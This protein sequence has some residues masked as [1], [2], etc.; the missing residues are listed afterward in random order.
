MKVVRT[1]VVCVVV[2]TLLCSDR[3]RAQAPVQVLARDGDTAPGAGGA[4]LNGLGRVVINSTGSAAFSAGL[5]GNGVTPDNDSSLWRSAGGI[6]TLIAREDV[7]A[8]GTPVGIRFAGFQFPAINNL[9]QVTFL[10]NL[11]GGTVNDTN[12]Y[13][14]W[15]GL[16]G[17]IQKAFRNGD[18]VPGIDAT[19]DVSVGV[20]FGYSS[21]NQVAF[22]GI[23]DDPAAP[24][25]QFGIWAGAPGALTPVAV[26][27]QQA[28]DLPAGV[29]FR[30]ALLPAMSPGGQ[31][32]FLATL[33]GPGISLGSDQGIWIGNT[34]TST[35]IAREGAAA[36]DTTLATYGNFG[37]PSI[38]DAGEIAFTN[39]LTGPGADSNNQR[40]IFAGAPGAIALVARE[41]ETALGT[42]PGVVF[43][44]FSERTLITGA[45]VVVSKVTLRGAG[46]SSDNNDGIWANP[47]GPFTRVARQGDP[48]P[49][50]GAL[51]NIVGAPTAN[52]HGQAAFR[53][54]LSGPDVNNSNDA[55]I[56]AV[57]PFN[58]LVLVAREGDSVRLGLG[59]DRILSSNGVLLVADSGGQDGFGSAFN[60]ASQLGLAFNFEDGTSAAIISRVGGTARVSDIAPVLGAAIN[61]GYGLGLPATAGDIVNVAGDTGYIRFADV[62]PAGTPMQILL[63]FGGTDA[64]LAAAL[65]EIAKGT[66]WYG[67]QF[68]A[69]GPGEFQ[70]RLDLTS[71]GSTPQFFYWNVLNI[72]NLDLQRV[73]FL[74]EPNT[75]LLLAIAAGAARARRHLI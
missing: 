46:V 45:G 66:D 60:S 11:R 54:T 5:T 61:N 15:A 17:G 24:G 71:A 56:W 7:Q 23:F 50:T 1:S 21:G 2:G 34:S 29:R 12:E 13:G 74:P 20:P 62:A 58:R 47:T 49:G 53:G 63:D 41:G 26:P 57:D 19:F 35:R 4:A 40:A 65:A 44:D 69:M 55:G 68:T 39:T 67:Y 25:S 36:P 3:A 30:D 6:L 59:E 22:T 43:D 72:G 38:N 16:P 10:G 42:T 8:P 75:L 48:A 73:Q 32:S 70:A 37:I 14:I 33:A 28:P 52:F 64:G 18:P 31:I 51:F 9:G 27:G